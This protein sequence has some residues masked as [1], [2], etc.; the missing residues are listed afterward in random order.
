MSTQKTIFSVFFSIIISISIFLVIMNNHD[1]SDIFIEKNS[2]L[3]K[4]GID[5]YDNLSN[6]NNNKIFL[7]GSSQIG[8]FNETNIQYSLLEKNLNFEIYNLAT[9]GDTPKKRL[10]TIDLILKSQ[11]TLI[12]Y[13]I[14][15]RDFTDVLTLDQIDKPVSILPDP[16]NIS[17]FIFTSFKNFFE[18]ELTKSPKTTTIKIIKQIIG[19]EDIPKNALNRPNTPFYHTDDSNSIILNDF[20]LKRSMSAFPYKLNSITSLQE[21][22]NVYALQEIIDEI[23]AH[24]INLII[25]TVPYSQYYLETITDH[26][27]NQFDLILD[28]LSN[29]LEIKVYEFHN[30][31]TN[32]NIWNSNDHI[33]VGNSSIIPNVE[34]SNIIS[35]SIEE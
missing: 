18:F 21:N 11:P 12:V 25:I 9:S 5:F 10:D 30:N 8:R 26:N 14:G 23:Y 3:N 20:E 32:S 4:N 22:E 27:K 13:G 31:F 7:L 15:Y 16:E 2:K 28:Y 17:T 29:E 24:K 6:S 33:A 34:L 19:E 35:K 1:Q